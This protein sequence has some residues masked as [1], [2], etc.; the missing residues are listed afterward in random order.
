MQCSLLKRQ[1]SAHSGS[2]QVRGRS[3]SSDFSVAERFELPIRQSDIP[4]QIDFSFIPTDPADAAVASARVTVPATIGSAEVGSS[5]RSTISSV[6]GSVA[7]RREIAASTSSRHCCTNFCAARSGGS[8]LIPRMNF[9][10][11]PFHFEPIAHALERESVVA[12]TGPPIHFERA[13]HF[14]R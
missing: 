7:N 13:D 11:L 12:N 6:S 4:G 14:A 3:G 9:P 2:H 1:A 5:T 8:P 10:R